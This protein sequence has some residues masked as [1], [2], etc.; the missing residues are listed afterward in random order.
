MP[1]GMCVAVF[2]KNFMAEVP[3]NIKN[4]ENESKPEEEKLAEE[5]SLEKES[6]SEER[7]TAPKFLRE[8]KAEIIK[9]SKN[10]EIDCGCRLPAYDVGPVKAYRGVQKGKNG[11]NCI[12]LVCEPH[13]IPRHR[14]T[15]IYSS[16][17]N[18]SL[19]TLQ[20]FGTV[21]WPPAE[22]ERYVFIYHNN[23]G[24]SIL[25]EGITSLGWKQDLVIEA[26]VKPMVSVLKDLASREFV[27]GS[28]RASNMFD[29]GISD[30]PKKI[31]LGDCLAVPSSYANPAIYQTIERSMLDPIGRGQGTLADDMYAL[32]V[33]LSVILR[34][35][36][37][38][39]GK[40]D[41]DILR[42][43][44]ELGSYAAVTG[45]DRFKGSI[46]ELLRGLLHDDPEQR[47]T[48]EETL[49]WLDGRRLSPKQSVKR[50]KAPRPIVFAKEKYL[51]PS[52]LAMDVAKHP[53]QLQV[54]V[55][56]GELEQWLSRALEDEV[57]VER[58][59]RAV[60][61]SKERGVGA[62][63]AERLA[64][65]VSTALDP[66]FPICYKD[67]RLTT[68]SLGPAMVEAIALGKDIQ[69]LVEII[70]QNV[71]LNWLFLQEGSLLDTASYKTRLD[72]CRNFVR[73]TKIG[74]GVERCLYTLFP[75]C[76]CLGSVLKNYVIRSPEDMMY[77]F[78]NLA[79]K[80]EAPVLFLDR[81]SAAYLSVNEP[82]VI[83]S[84]LFDLGASEKY[85][86]I[87]GNLR[88]LSTIQRRFSLPAFPGIAKVFE[89]N[90]LVV[91]ERY[92]DREIRE[93]LQKKISD[94]VKGG[95]LV[96]MAA[97]L[98]D[99]DTLNE[100][101]RGFSLAM[102]E[103]MY[104]SK[105]KENLE[106]RLKDKNVFGKTAGQS[107]SAIVASLLSGVT[108]LFIV[109]MFFSQKTPI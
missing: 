1:F 50:T 32:G 44:I 39:E 45:K 80:G 78:E 13:L 69:I 68:E 93:S 26:V 82:K 51:Y 88:C 49:I 103:Y 67:V 76:H 36:D 53:Q 47:W 77:A 21:Y 64:A 23:L 56:N 31:I 38:F 10:I 4:T 102:T 65:A 12:V 84:Y 98:D 79:Q 66:C 71:A 73:Q 87:L 34:T 6:I 15:S 106:M 95:S 74:Y 104:L 96:K 11:Q 101:L 86:N 5:S 92:H 94:Y 27:H 35:K 61:V 37:H 19:A 8:K 20:A 83:D 43:K 109:F 29:G 63:Y 60:A 24:K 14:A 62:G 46:L 16:I 22:A 70:S 108:I 58:F 91:Y 25:R 41:D 59:T 107:V 105:E 28:I 72:S 57:V 85:R 30:V 3:E 7:K 100:D 17:S 2:R 75:D 18:S 89:E 33:S 81:H 99:P 90:L 48:V 54:L 9:F 52:F 55:E 40:S 42:S 97:L